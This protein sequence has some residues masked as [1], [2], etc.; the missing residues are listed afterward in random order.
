MIDWILSIHICP[1][2]YQSVNVSLSFEVMN[3]DVVIPNIVTDSS[4]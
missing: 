3:H 1:Q 4:I 2:H